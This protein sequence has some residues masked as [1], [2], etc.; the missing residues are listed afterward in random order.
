M[1]TIMPRRM[2]PTA[3]MGFLM[4]FAL[5]NIMFFMVPRFWLNDASTNTTML[6]WIAR[7][8]GIDSLSLF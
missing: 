4:L 5:L 6:R 1:N 2:S 7:T 8:V 3:G